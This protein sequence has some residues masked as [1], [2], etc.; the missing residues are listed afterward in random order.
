MKPHERSGGEVAGKKTAN[1][2]GPNK[3]DA[4]DWSA[5]RQA[6]RGI[7][8]A[9]NSYHHKMMGRMH[10]IVRPAFLFDQFLSLRIS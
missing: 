9:E 2:N 8:R 3:K 10:F 1:Q 6:A 5:V 4:S 7:D